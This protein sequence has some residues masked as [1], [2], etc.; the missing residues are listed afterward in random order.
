M[1]EPLKENKNPPFSV[2]LHPLKKVPKLKIGIETKR[3]SIECK[4]SSLFKMYFG[5]V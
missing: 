1:A 2:D 5:N 3:F 4:K